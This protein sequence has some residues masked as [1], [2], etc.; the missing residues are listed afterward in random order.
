VHL[1]PSANVAE[2]LVALAYAKGCQDEKNQRI[3][4]MLLNRVFVL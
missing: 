2:M 4:F 3:V 1:L